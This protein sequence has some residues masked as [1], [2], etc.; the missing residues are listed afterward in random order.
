MEQPS[1]A[2]VALKWGIIIAVITG[3]YSVVSYTTGLFK[4]GF[5]SAVNYLFLLF[6]II[7]AIREFRAL[8]E[9]F[10]SFGES[11]GVGTLVSAVTG[12]ISSVFAYVYIFFID[13]TLMGQMQDLQRDNWEAQG[14]TEEQ[15]NQAIEISAPFTT[16]GFMFLIGLLVYMLIGFVCSLI[17]SA[18]MKRDKP[19]MN[20]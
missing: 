10:I 20:F 1:T 18:I 6:G 7:L 9:N 2:R 13:T 12:V 16:P 14:L 3:I 11:L 8:N 19:E 15:I 17:I 5:S 4:S